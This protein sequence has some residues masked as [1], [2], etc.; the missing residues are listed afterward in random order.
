MADDITAIRAELAQV[1]EALERLSHRST[2]LETAMARIEEH[3][4]GIRELLAERC[5]LRGTTQAELCSR[6]R[7]LEQRQWWAAGFAAAASFVASWLIK[8]H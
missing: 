6:V 8:A 2:V 3:L 5:E 7:T 1:W 4:R